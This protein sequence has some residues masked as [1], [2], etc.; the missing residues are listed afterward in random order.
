MNNSRLNNTRLLRGEVFMVT[1]A[2]YAQTIYEVIRREY[3]PLRYA[4]E[5][6]AR[7]AGVS[8]RTAQNW[9][10]GA[11]A[12]QGAALLNLMKNNEEVA[13]EMARLMKMARG[14]D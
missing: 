8:S 9:L 6:L 13:A 10:S 11:N 2:S 4:S 5:V 12:P 3:G 14:D 7:A 1:P